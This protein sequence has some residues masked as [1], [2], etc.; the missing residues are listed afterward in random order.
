MTTTRVYTSA[1]SGAPSMS[2]GAAGSAIAVIKACLVDGYG[3]KAPAGWTM[4]YSTSGKAAFRNSV[5]AG[6][7]GAYTRIEDTLTASTSRYTLQTYV[8]MSD[9]DTGVS[10][11]HVVSAYRSP[12]QTANANSW[13]L[14]ADERTFWFANTDGS[15]LTSA[16]SFC[17]GGTGSMEPIRTATWHGGPTARM[18]TRK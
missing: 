4:P 3:S 18:P 7:T 12:A 17:G 8:S 16:H 2:R 1:D 9:V 5:A 10:G 13:I 15:T 6:G 14:A 11:T